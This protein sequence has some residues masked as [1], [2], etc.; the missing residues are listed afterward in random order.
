VLAVKF[1][2]EDEQI[3]ILNALWRR[4]NDFTTDEINE[5][6]DKIVGGKNLISAN[7]VVVSVFLNN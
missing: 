2:T 7:G 3:A 5:D 1:F 6:A 4:Q